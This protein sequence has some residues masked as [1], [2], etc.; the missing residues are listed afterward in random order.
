MKKILLMEDLPAHALELIKQ[1]EATMYHVTWARNATEALDHLEKAQFDV[2]IADILVRD[3]PNLA[4]KGGVTLIGK[5]RAAAISIRVGKAIKPIPVIA[6]S[7]KFHEGGEP[8]YLENTALGVGA[9]A[10]L[11]KPVDMKRLRA[12]IEE[13]TQV[14][15]RGGE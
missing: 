1:L 3:G 15:E 9:D 6:I 11:P 10:A 8:N 2:V 13:L 5:I 4:A 7:A 14:T 12:L